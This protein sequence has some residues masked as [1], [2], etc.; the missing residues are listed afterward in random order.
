MFNDQLVSFSGVQPSG[1]LTI[2][3]YLGALKN[4]SLYSE[5]Y[6]TFYCVVDEH[7]ITV[8][9]VPADLRRRTY[10]TLALYI[11]AGLDPEKNTLFVQSHVPGHAQLSWDLGCF[12][13][14]GELSRMTQF[15][16]KSQKNADN[17]NAG[18]FTY[19][20]LM[21]ADILLYRADLVPVGIDQKQHLEL[22]RDIAERF[23]GIYG[24]TF[25]VP[26]GYIPK[27]GMKIMSL[28]DP[29]KKMSK[30][31][32]DSN[33]SVGILDGRDDIIRKFKRAVT[34]SE[35]E[36]R[37]AEGKDGI[38]NLMSIYSCFTGKSL[39]Q[40]EAEFSGKGY[41][42]FKLAVGETVADGLAPIRTEFARLMQDKAYLEEVMKKGAESASRIASR[43][44]SKVHKKLGFVQLR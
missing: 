7:A 24:D 27:T 35:T 14:F 41:G 18:L 3:N 12:T 39:E 40:I 42:E 43:T 2:G 26:D 28:S 23:N 13:M 44:L 8:R 15:K 17:I 9:Q 19:P 1:N 5:K 22:A 31:D 16:D 21:A 11:A 6:K 32:A 33:A 30:S 4:F 38:N 37:Y 36:V 10:E 29:T 20:V 25:T 34:D